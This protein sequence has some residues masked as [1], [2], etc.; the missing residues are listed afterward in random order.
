LIEL[1]VIRQRLGDGT[2]FELLGK[3]FVGLLGG[4]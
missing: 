4:G 2:E 3:G 1:A